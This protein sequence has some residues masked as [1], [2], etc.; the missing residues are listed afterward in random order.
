MHSSTPKR[1]LYYCG[2]LRGELE[3]LREKV[4]TKMAILAW[5]IWSGRNEKV[6]NNTTIPNT[7]LLARLQRLITEHDKYAKRIYGSRMGGGSVMGPA[8][9]AISIYCF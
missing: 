6:F 9:Y 3:I 1:D 8:Q 4:A 5:C 2:G 7:V